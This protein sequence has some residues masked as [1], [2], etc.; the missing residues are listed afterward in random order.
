MPLMSGAW[1][2]RTAFA[3]PDMDASPRHLTLS[4]RGWFRLIAVGLVLVVMLGVARFVMLELAQFER[5]SQG[6]QAVGKLR[7]A[8]VAAEMVSRERG[9]TNGVLGD[10]SAG[11]P[12]LRAALSQARARTDR[13]IA[14]F[15]RVLSHEGAN[16]RYQQARREASTFHL[17]LL[18]ARAQ[19]DQQASQPWAERSP[20]GIRDSVRGMVALVPRLAPAITLFA[21]DAQQSDPRLAASV[22]GARMAAELREYAGQLG[23]LF[24]PALTRQQPFSTQERDAI[25]QV[26]GRIDE[27]HHLIGLQVGQDN[28]SDA[29]LASHAAMEQ[30]YFGSAAR[31]LDAVQAAGRSDGRY[32]LTPAAFAQQYVPRMDAILALRDVLLEDAERRSAQTRERSRDSLAWL[33]AL[34]TV[35]LG[36]VLGMLHLTRQRIIL[37][38]SQAA[39]ALHA[40]GSGDFSPPLPVARADDEISAVIGG[41]AALRQQSLARLELERERD[42]LIETLR[43]Q[44]TT[45]FL[46]RLPNRRAFFEVA[47]AEMARAQRHGFGVVVLLMDVDHF[48]RVNDSRGHTAGDLALVSV[49]QVLRQS[50]RQGDLSARLGGEEFVA[51]LSHCSPDA[52]VAF[53][54]RVREAIQAQ[55]VD[56]GPG[57]APLHLT[58]S[59]GLADSVHHGHD[60]DALLACADDAMYRAKRM[61][62]NRTERARPP[63]DVSESARLL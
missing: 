32:G 34:T 63:A 10:A 23:S 56:V 27:L 48:K 19:V 9:P 20:Q 40:M 33:V 12:A 44:S 15:Q 42:K 13:A 31:L 45:D 50:L 55:A 1:T 57:Q 53:A 11:D 21:D 38:L 49:A 29:I 52:G 37:P 60:L 41:I 24:T 61:G 5:A 36:L 2:R 58:V 3:A 46:T 22:W 39:D 16:L 51:L 54:E 7:V 26:K 62:R 43:E 25:E 59:I 6:M 47:Q 8:L 4:L 18:Q 28:P 17:A 14:D 35:L 30:G